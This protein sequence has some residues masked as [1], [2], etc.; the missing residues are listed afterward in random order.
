[1]VPTVKHWGKPWY[2]GG[3]GGTVVLIA[4]W[5]ITRMEGNP[6][7]GRGLNVNEMGMAVEALQA[8]FIGL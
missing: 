3:I 5:V 1:M 8:A 4:I 7:T 2:A 6:I